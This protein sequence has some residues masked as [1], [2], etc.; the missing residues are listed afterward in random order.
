MPSKREKKW[1]NDIHN[2][3]KDPHTK[4]K[5]INR[6]KKKIKRV[7]YSYHTQMEAAHSL[8]P[9]AVRFCHQKCPQSA[10]GSREE[11]GGEGSE[12]EREREREWE[13]EWSEET[14][15]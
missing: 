11:R 4:Y 15:K 5:A 8:R 12:K 2:T 10:Q 1:K 6:N 14:E 7:L 9:A 13:W 3:H